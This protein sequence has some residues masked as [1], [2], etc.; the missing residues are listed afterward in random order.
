M[1]HTVGAANALAWVVC[2]QQPVIVGAYCNYQVRLQLVYT[3]CVQ[4]QMLG[5]KPSHARLHPLYTIVLVVRP[6]KLQ[7]G[8]SRLLSGLTQPWIPGMC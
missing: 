1:G 7:S 8:L 4:M 3:A 6:S 2:Q 5:H